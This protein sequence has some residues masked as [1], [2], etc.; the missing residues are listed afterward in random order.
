MAAKAPRK[1]LGSSGGGGAG[2]SNVAS[3]SSSGGTF[4]MIIFW[5]PILICVVQCT[6]LKSTRF[7][8]ELRV[9]LLAAFTNIML[10]VVKNI[11]KCV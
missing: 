4:F 5:N 9:L 10:S 6:T 7:M 3:P 11:T 8:L 1:V 2:A